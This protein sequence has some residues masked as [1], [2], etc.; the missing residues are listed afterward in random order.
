MVGGP[1]MSRSSR[2]RVPR[3]LASFAAL[4]SLALA[5]GTTAASAPVGHFTVGTGAA[6]KTVFDTKTK[7]TWQQGFSAG[8]STWSDSQSVCGGLSLNG[9]G[10]R[11]PTMAELV[12]LV[13][14]RASAAPFIDT[15]VFPGTPSSLF[16]TATPVAGSTSQAW[17]IHFDNG[18]GN[19]FDITSKGYV[20]CVR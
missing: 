11:Q 16:W 6:A 12:T 15:T 8:T 4:A 9:S 7:L 10:W 13:D 20:R 5:Q 1:F 14:F 19:A 18:D 2:H 3:H 17:G